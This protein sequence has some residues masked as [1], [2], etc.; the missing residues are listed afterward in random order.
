MQEKYMRERGMDAEQVREQC[1]EYARVAGVDEYL[2]YRAEPDAGESRVLASSIESSLPSR[3]GPAGWARGWVAKK[4]VGTY[5]GTFKNSFIM[6]ILKCDSG[7]RHHLLI[8]SSSA[9]SK[10]PCFSLRERGFF[11]APKFDNSNQLNSR[12][13]SRCPPSPIANSTELG[14]LP[15]T[16]RCHLRTSTQT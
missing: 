3:A 5:V 9:K 1:E 15:S 13:N 14:W 16:R 10:K 12:D 7:R 4:F 6:A 11:C 2:T 8:R